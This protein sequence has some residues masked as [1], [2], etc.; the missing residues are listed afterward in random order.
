[1]HILGEF[2][3]RRIPH[4]D[5]CIVRTYNV[6]KPQTSKWI[7][8]YIYET[9]VLVVVKYNYKVGAVKLEFHHILT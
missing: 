1:M 8:L 4:I 2:E 7:L 9:G 3:Q 6:A 5:Q